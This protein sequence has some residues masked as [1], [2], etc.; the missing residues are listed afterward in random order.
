MPTLLERCNSL[1]FTI[2]SFG[3]D[4][5]LLNKLVG[6][7]DFSITF[8]QAHSV[9]WNQR[10][11]PEGI[12]SMHEV[13][14]H[15]DS[16]MRSRTWPTVRT[17]EYK[18]QN[19]KQIWVSERFEMHRY[20]SSIGMSQGYRQQTRDMMRVCMMSCSIPTYASSSVPTRTVSQLGSYSPTHVPLPSR[21][22]D[23]THKTVGI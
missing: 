20:K 5:K 6:S 21:E 2:C 7:P 13:R 1:Y 4:N 18:E 16:Q 8:G 3:M 9:P 23:F 10:S 11:D 15:P 17:N 19:C 14:F 22:L 12:C